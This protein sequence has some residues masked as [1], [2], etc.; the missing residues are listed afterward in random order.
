MAQSQTPPQTMTQ[1][2]LS[3]ALL[4]AAIGS[5]N[6]LGRNL[7]RVQQNEISMGEACRDSLVHGAAASFITTTATAVCSGISRY[8]MLRHASFVTAVGVLSY[9]VYGLMPGVAAKTG[10][11]SAEKQSA[12]Q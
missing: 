11:P 6:A 9:G 12:P 5:A 1:P 7:H 3:A 8:P 10:K 4:G 2:L